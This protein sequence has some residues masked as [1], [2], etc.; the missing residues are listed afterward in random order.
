MRGVQSDASAYVPGPT[1][2]NTTSRDSA[3]TTDACA[4]ARAPR[5]ADTAPA[6]GAA[7][8]LPARLPLTP[9]ALNLTSTDP[10]SPSRRLRTGAAA[11][12]HASLSRLERQRPDRQ[13][14]EALQAAACT[15]AGC[16]PPEL[17]TSSNDN[18][19]PTAPR[20]LPRPACPPVPAQARAATPRRQGAPTPGAGCAPRASWRCAG[21]AGPSAGCGA[22][23]PRWT[24]PPAPP[25]PAP[26]P[27]GG[28]LKC[29]QR[30]DSVASRL[31]L[32]EP[33][34]AP[35]SPSARGACA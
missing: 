14:A 16:A 20:A 21:R 5:P 9:H 29:L 34:A 22:R 18:T 4:P 30:R 6:Q 32:G 31:T 11:G 13:A 27:A 2:P 1:R 25:P 19:H 33:H 17:V 35:A 23:S 26:A 3:A 10:A 28:H 7:L 24:A 15:Q 8:G 12:A